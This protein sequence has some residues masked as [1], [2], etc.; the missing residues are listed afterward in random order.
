MWLGR[1]L[2]LVAYNRAFLS[3]LDPFIEF[4]PDQ[5]E[6]EGDKEKYTEIN[7]RETYFIVFIDLFSK[8]KSTVSQLIDLILLKKKL[9]IVL[10]TYLVF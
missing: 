6:N 9:T 4:I 3:R 5:V 7:Y 10:G 1:I 8:V 2:R